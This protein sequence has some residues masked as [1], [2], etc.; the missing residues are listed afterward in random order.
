[1]LHKTKK[2]GLL[3]P[4]AALTLAPLWLARPAAAAGTANV[5][6]T[7]ASASVTNGNNITVNVYEDSGSD[8]VNAVQ[9]NLTYSTSQ[10][11]YVSYSNSGSPF[12]IE[13]QNP[14]GDTG[15]LD[16][17]R[18][19]TTPVS[20]AQLVVSITFKAV[21]SSGTAAVNFANGTAVVRSSDNGSET[22]NETG[23]SYTLT[24]PAA[25]G[26]GGGG[27]GGGSG[28]G[29]STPPKKTSSPAPAPSSP[30]SPST[31]APSATTLSISSVHVSNVTP[32]SATISWQTSAAASSEIDYGVDVNYE[33]PKS[34]S[35][36]VTSHQI[37]ITAS[38]GLRPATTYHF[39]VK[40][41]DASGNA[42]ASADLTFQTPAATGSTPTPIKPSGQN[43]ET[44]VAAAGG[45][46]LAAA[47]VVLFLV[48]RGLQHRRM[49]AELNRH[50]AV[51]LTP[52]ADKPAPP[53]N[54]V[55]A[56]SKPAAPQVT[57]PPAPPADKNPPK[58]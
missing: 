31:P 46:V 4:A 41:V 34:D 44:E 6:L 5:Y 49:Q 25:S 52:A 37:T 9:A 14:S 19:T 38:D 24:A 18:G 11:S 47:L 32:T 15:S 27:G 23:G 33:V 1:M 13:A 57:P 45:G 20:G 54:S 16:F 26:G 50:F 55:I 8:S 42:A 36:M 58:P 12:T 17:A 28:G 51:P 21:A 56:P 30:S 39:K 2:L 40:S 29:S 43:T 53:A 22:L 10:L 3:I 35:Q 48:H 7:P